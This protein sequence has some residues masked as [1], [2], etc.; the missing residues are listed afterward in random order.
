MDRSGKECNIDSALSVICDSGAG[1]HKR[2][3]VGNFFTAC[4]IGDSE[5][6]KS[7]LYEHKDGWGKR[8]LGAK[9]AVI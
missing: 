2:S 6:I 4:D 1:E 8:L 9:V 3:L 5:Y 7:L